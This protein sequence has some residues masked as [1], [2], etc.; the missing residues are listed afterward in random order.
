[1]I[2]HFHEARRSMLNAGYGQLEI[3]VA[4]DKI[5]FNQAELTGNIWM[6]KLDVK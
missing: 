2:Y 5:V 4:R 1:M 3:S 6:G